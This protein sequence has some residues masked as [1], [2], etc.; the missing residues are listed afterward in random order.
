MCAIS[1]PILENL[2]TLRIVSSCCFDEG[3]EHWVFAVNRSFAAA[4]DVVDA[5]D[6][7]G[8]MSSWC[9]EDSGSSVVENVLRVLF[10][11]LFPLM[12]LF[13]S[14][15]PCIVVF[16]VITLCSLSFFVFHKLIQVVF[17]SLGWS[18]C[19][20]L[21]SRRYDLSESCRLPRRRCNIFCFF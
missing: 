1:R 19:S 11:F 16:Q 9:C 7:V 2:R 4:G 21:R 14:S 5:G 20:S 15:E 13:C 10:F 12:D 6:R 8:V 3:Q 18:S 17:P